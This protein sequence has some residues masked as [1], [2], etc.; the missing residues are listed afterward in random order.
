MNYELSSLSLSNSVSKL[1]RVNLFFV[2]I[3]NFIAL[4]HRLR[5]YQKYIADRGCGARYQNLE[6]EDA[7]ILNALLALSTRFSPSLYFADTP[8]KDR[9]RLFVHVAKSI[10]KDAMKLN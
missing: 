3:S 9:G 5:F 7:L 1:H 2:K 8:L 10:Y 4:F 6:T